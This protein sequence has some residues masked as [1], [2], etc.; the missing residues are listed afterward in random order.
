[1]MPI[2]NKIPIHSGDQLCVELQCIDRGVFDYYNTLQQ[3]V[4]QSS[5]TPANPASNITGGA[6]GYFSAHT[7]NRRQIVVP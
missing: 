4:E 5:A 2:E 3:T 1:V 7:I 6:L